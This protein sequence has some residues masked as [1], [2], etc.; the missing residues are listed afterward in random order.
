MW[1]AILIEFNRVIDMIDKGHLENV[2]YLDL[3]RLWLNSLPVVVVAVPSLFTFYVR[4]AK[5]DVKHI[6]L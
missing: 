3:K 2:L 5:N 4:V 1:R 6:H